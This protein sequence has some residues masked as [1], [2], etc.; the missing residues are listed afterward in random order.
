MAGKNFLENLPVCYG[1]TGKP[2]STEGFLS[3]LTHHA[4]CPMMYTCIAC[5]TVCSPCPPY[6]IPRIPRHP[7]FMSKASQSAESPR[8][9]IGVHTFP[10]FNLLNSVFVAFFLSFLSFFRSSSMLPKKSNLYSVT[11]YM[12]HFSLLLC[13]HTYNSASNQYRALILKIFFRV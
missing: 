12:L 2:G 7:A 3:I 6:P 13:P 11:M 10:L 5:C 4:H 9:R 1:D 8:A